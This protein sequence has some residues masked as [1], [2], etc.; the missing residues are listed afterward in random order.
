MFV[1]KKQRFSEQTL[2]FYLKETE[3]FKF[4]LL[5]F[6]GSIRQIPIYL[7]LKVNHYSSDSLEL[8]SYFGRIW[9][10]FSVLV[11][12]HESACLYIRIKFLPSR[13]AQVLGTGGYR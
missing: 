5:F 9:S 2:L 12:I 4:T 1:P 8:D 11:T 13:I 7:T 6:L 10:L 3:K